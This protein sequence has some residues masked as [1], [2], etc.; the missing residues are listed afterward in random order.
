MITS[1]TTTGNHVIP[2][3]L[4]TD[5]T[6]FHASEKP[7]RVSASSESRKRRRLLMQ[8]G[9]SFEHPVGGVG[10]KNWFL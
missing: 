5:L 10:A 9:Y 8:L 6:S 4:Y 2:R 7:F 3:A 1:P